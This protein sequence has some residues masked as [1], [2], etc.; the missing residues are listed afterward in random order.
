MTGR[1]AAAEPQSLVRR[2][3][4]RRS[5]ILLW[6]NTLVSIL[7]FALGLLLLW[8]LVEHGGTPKLAAA[9]LSFLFSNTLH[10]GF[11]RAWIYRGTK[12][13]VVAGYTYFLLN[14][15]IG[16]VITLGLFAGFMALGLHYLLA[17]IVASIFAGL[18]L[19]LLNATLNFRCL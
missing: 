6:R 16:L 5:A 19:F 8:L 15:V 14:A 9:A 7:V 12:R 4:S 10:Y 11:G 13:Q 18:A 2:L 17:R 1:L 3:F